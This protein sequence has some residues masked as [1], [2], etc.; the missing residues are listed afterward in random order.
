MYGLGLN[1]TEVEAEKVDQLISNHKDKIAGYKQQ[2]ERIIQAGMRHASLSVVEE[3]VQERHKRA[4]MKQVEREGL[5]GLDLKQLK[6]QRRLIDQFL[7]AS[8]EFNDQIEN[9]KEWQDKLRRLNKLD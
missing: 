7:R 3:M 1:S 5:T 2:R 4:L 9:P 8:K 6:R